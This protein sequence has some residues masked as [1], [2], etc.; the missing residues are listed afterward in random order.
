MFNEH[1]Y[2]LIMFIVL[3]GNGS[4]GVGVVSLCYLLRFLL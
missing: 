4:Q 2:Q 1:A 3:A